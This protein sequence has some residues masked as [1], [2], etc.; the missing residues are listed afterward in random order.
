MLRFYLLS[1]L[2]L[3]ALLTACSPTV[4]PA[5]TPSVSTA[6]VTPL[7]A[8]VTR[9]VTPSPRANQAS[10]AQAFLNQLSAGRS[11][12]TAKAEEWIAQAKMTANSPT[13]VVATLVAHDGEQININPSPD[14]RWQ[15]EVVI[16]PYR[17]ISGSED[18]HSYEQLRLINLTSGEELALADQLISRGGIGA[19]GLAVAYWS[20]DS[21][22]LYYTDAREGVPDGGD[23]CWDPPLYRYDVLDGSR[24]DLRSGP[25]SLNGR[26]IAMRYDGEL[27]LWDL[28]Q[29]EIGRAPAIATGELI[30]SLAWSLDGTFILYLL[31][32]G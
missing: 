30:Q 22:F 28:D 4:A 6:R 23:C 1:I 31:T 15:A 26:I 10:T 7:L 29:G 13:R 18:E 2:V 5:L 8:T 21:R 11:T 24:L 17:S 20:S 9:T 27:V 32:E 16:Y 19:S 25:L 12:A 3:L 14:G